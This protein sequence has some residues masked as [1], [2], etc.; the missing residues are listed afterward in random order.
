MEDIVINLSDPNLIGQ[1]SD[2]NL[3][4]IYLMRHLIISYSLNTSTDWH[5]IEELLKDSK[6]SEFFRYSVAME[7]IKK[8]L[9]E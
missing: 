7:L 5:L 4:A 8:E 1:A 2:P 9:L 3:L 6:Y